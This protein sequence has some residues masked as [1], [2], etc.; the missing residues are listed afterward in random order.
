MMG[1]PTTLYKEVSA[2]GTGQRRKLGK[3][4]VK[5]DVPMEPSKEATV[6][7]MGERPLSKHAVMM[8][9]QTL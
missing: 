5:K 8:G 2:R 3:Y 7:S 1:A 6:G 9:A 4:A